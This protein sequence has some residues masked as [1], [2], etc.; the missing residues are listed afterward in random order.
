M[1]KLTRVETTHTYYSVDVTD[2][3]VIEARKGDKEFEALLSLVQGKMKT[4][5][6]SDSKTEFVIE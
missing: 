5:R 4:T 3:Q 2:A 6:P 1:P